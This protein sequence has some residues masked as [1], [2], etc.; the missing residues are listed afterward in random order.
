MEMKFLNSSKFRPISSITEDLYI[1]KIGSKLVSRSELLLMVCLTLR[2]LL[3]SNFGVA[4]FL[5]IQLFHAVTPPNH[6]CPNMHHITAGN[7]IIL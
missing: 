1:T 6:N 2:R 3:Q 4:F 5:R 7:N